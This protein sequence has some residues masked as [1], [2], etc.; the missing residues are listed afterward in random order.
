MTNG[1]PAA[2]TSGNATDDERQ[3]AQ[4][5]PL[6]TASAVDAAAVRQVY[7]REA[8]DPHA[9]RAALDTAHAT[10][11]LQDDPALHQA[12]TPSELAA[13]RDQVER[14]RADLRD[15]ADYDHRADL[16]DRN[17]RRRAGKA[18]A[19]R[20]RVHDARQERARQR[21]EHATQAAQRRRERVL[22]PTADLVRLHR[23]LR[24]L[25]L[26]ALL[27]AAI[28]TAAGSIN[29]GGELLRITGADSPAATALAYM[30]EI[31]FTLPLLVIM[32]TQYVAATRTAGADNERTERFAAAEVLLLGVTVA[33]NVGVH[34]IP[35]ATGAPADGPGAL[36]WVL[37][38]CGLAVSMWLTPR[39]LDLLTSRF[40]QTARE[41]EVSAPAGSLTTADARLA[42]ITRWV[43]EQDRAGNLPGERDSETG[44]PS[45]SGVARAVKTEFGSCSKPQARHIVDLYGVLYDPTL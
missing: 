13:D 23:G 29:V 25:P 36:L 42:R 20:Q 18:H 37:V 35:S 41:A 26:G 12:L 5:P 27:P 45:A 4:P 2:L 9:V 44:L 32:G 8:P 34:W 11:E 30:V 10:V 19:R 43:A 17:A 16:A 14:H 28:A 6:R 33:L 3:G 39:V 15:Q 21:H 31:L 40:R 24:I 22:D 38:P 7:G 1:R